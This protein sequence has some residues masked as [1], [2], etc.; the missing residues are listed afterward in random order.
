MP[1]EMV[2][3]LKHIGL[4]QTKPG[5]LVIWNGHFAFVCADPSD[6]LG[7]LSLTV[8]KPVVFEYHFFT[9]YP[10]VVTLGDDLLIAPT[11]DTAITVTKIGASVGMAL[12]LDNGAPFV[13]VTIPNTSEWRVLDLTSGILRKQNSSE[14]LAIPKWRLGIPATN[15]DRMWVLDI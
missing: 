6:Q 4:S 14:Y 11:V 15:G 10:D 9:S 12:F 13:V 1:L 7:R 8:V 5:D 3:S 2:P